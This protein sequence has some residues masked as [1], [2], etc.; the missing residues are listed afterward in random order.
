MELD[1]E[2]GFCWAIRTRT[3]GLPDAKGDLI[4]MLAYARDRA[5]I[6][7]VA[8]TDNDYIGGKLR[9]S[10]RNVQRRRRG[11]A[12]TIVV[13]ACRVDDGEVGAVAPPAPLGAVRALR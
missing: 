8:I 5:Q 6:S 1:G 3:Q 4:E 2:P 12:R 11:R 13:R 9:I 7:F 10:L